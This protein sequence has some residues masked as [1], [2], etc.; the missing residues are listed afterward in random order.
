MYFL[1]GFVCDLRHRRPVGRDACV[2]TAGPAG[3]RHLLRGRALPLR[4]DRRCSVP[5]VRRPALLVPE[6]D[7]KNAARGP[8]QSFF[9]LLFIGF[10]V[11]FF[12]MHFLG[13]MGMPRRV[14]TYE[15]GTGWG[16]LSLLASL[17]ALV[18]VFGVLMFLINVFVSR[19]S[20]AIAGDNPWEAGTLE[21]ATSSPPPPYNFAYLPVVQ[22]R[23]PLW[24]TPP[25][26]RGRVVG[27]RT[28][29]SRSSGNAHDGRT[30]GP[31]IHPAWAIHL[32]ILPRRN[33][34]ARPGRGPCF[35]CG[36]PSWAGCFR[37]S[38]SSPGSGRD[39]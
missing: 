30:S 26:R 3:A 14:Y 23:Q 37:S 5:A 6:D 34:D 21:W 33:G 12:P 11:T 28:R 35:R 20:G 13:M 16:S 29:S 22:G 19:G 25:E 10:N 1:A 31:S 4:S 27:L 15:P 32:A 39:A 38:R 18:M 17:G 7:R 2:G 24:E 8:R 9:W 36:G